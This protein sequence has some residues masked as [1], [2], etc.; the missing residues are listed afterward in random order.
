MY[1]FVMMTSQRSDVYV[2][3]FPIL[4]M[5]FLYFDLPFMVISSCGILAINVAR[6]VHRF[7]FLGENSALE[8]TNNT[9][10]LA[11][12]VLFLF[13]ISL[14][15]KLSNQF[16]K[17]KTE[18]IRIQQESQQHLLREILDVGLVLNQ[19]S[20]EIKN[21]FETLFEST[22]DVTIAVEEM[23]LNTNEA[24]E[25]LEA[26]RVITNG[27]HEMLEETCSMAENI[28]VLSQTSE[29]SLKEGI[30]VVTDLTSHADVV[31]SSGDNVHKT[32]V[33][34]EDK[35]K[36]IQD[37]V[38]VITSISEQTNM[39]A[40]N[41]AIESAR[42]GEAGRG[43]AVVADEIRKLAEQSKAS[44]DHIV[45]ILTE[46]R[47]KTSETALAI[48]ELKSSN[49]NQN[50]LI[51]TAKQRLTESIE[52]TLELNSGIIGMYDKMA[53][54][55]VE[56]NGVV[57]QIN[58]VAAASQENTLHVGK[59]ADMTSSNI[60]VATKANAYMEEFIELSEKMEKYQEDKLYT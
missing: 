22:N 36:D 14:A 16:N 24:D 12:V 28:K 7:Y 47:E 48:D 30:K 55:L 35:A 45:G 60:D 1:G 18:R 42:A 17:E 29:Q 21:I 53:Q 19:R 33:E 41:A 8:V 2:Y 9:I 32:M 49:T 20:N 52:K 56:N 31:A 54:V 50:Q 23:R 37:I 51:V 59:V 39:L 15:T 58:T 44:T 34:L 27:I 11:A 13:A 40:L 4:S 3:I 25:S 26:Q 57:G 46:L 6:L 38:G 10:H 43:F 5:Y